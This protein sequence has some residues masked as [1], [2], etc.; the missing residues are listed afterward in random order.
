MKQ[1]TLENI[2][3]KFDTLCTGA[4]LYVPYSL[5]L[6]SN[7]FK[8]TALCVQ[9]YST[10]YNLTSEVTTLCTILPHWGLEG[11]GMALK[12]CMYIKLPMDL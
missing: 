12:P 3:K 5:L 6:I 7:M 1:E 10:V 2:I 11:G 9:A 8:F 4:F